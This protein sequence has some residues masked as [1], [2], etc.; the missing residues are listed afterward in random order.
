MSFMTGDIA[1]IITLLVFLLFFVLLVSVVVVLNK[2]TKKL[3]NKEKDLK[4]IKV[5]KW[6]W[7]TKN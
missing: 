3:N 4:N 1:I 7:G 2:Y 5:T 6:N